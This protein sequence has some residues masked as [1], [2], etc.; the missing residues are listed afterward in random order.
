[1]ELNRGCTVARG[2]PG[3]R[4]H[5]VR[6]VRCEPVELLAI[7]SREAKSCKRDRGWLWFDVDEAFVERTAPLA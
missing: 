6:S 5:A 4:P 2:G 3:Q 7:V 1:M